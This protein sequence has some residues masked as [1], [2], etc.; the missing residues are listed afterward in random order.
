MRRPENKILV[1]FA[2]ASIWLAFNQGEI[3][4]WVSNW[5]PGA[6]IAI[7]VILFVAVY[8]ALCW[9]YWSFPVLTRLLNPRSFLNGD[10]VYIIRDDSSRHDHV[11]GMFR[12][13]Q[14]ED[15][16]AARDGVNW[17]SDI[18]CPGHRATWVGTLTPLDDDAAS[19][20]L[21]FTVTMLDGKPLDAPSGAQYLGSAWLQV[22]ERT[23]VFSAWPVLR[24]GTPRAL[25]GFWADFG[26]RPHHGRIY[27][28]QVPSGLD[29]AER[30]TRAQALAP[31]LPE[32]PPD[33][34]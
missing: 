32:A 24:T 15:R 2:I 3:T 17:Y 16:I 34:G 10:W 21:W 30:R 1:G 7:P 8:R 27:A 20:S 23:E 13:A 19:W 14:L 12:I 6:S 28:V 11:Y 25:K 18:D 26:G 29:E 33:D 31:Q 5:F 9:I 4:S 22:V